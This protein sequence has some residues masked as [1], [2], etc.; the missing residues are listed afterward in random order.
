MSP[1][2]NLVW[3]AACPEISR[4][5][6]LSVS[7][8]QPNGCITNA[9]LLHGTIHMTVAACCHYAGLEHWAVLGKD[10][11]LEYCCRYCT[12]RDFSGLLF[13][14]VTLRASHSKILRPSGC[15][16]TS[17]TAYS[18]FLEAPKKA[19]A[20]LAPRVFKSSAKQSWLLQQLDSSVVMEVRVLHFP[21][22]TQQ[23]LK[24]HLWS[25]STY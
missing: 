23:R 18:L 2:G 7:L 24:S 14:A 10:A 25:G 9:Q 16:K 4:S 5:R 3:D 20:L 22:A 13:F 8:A 17:P 19:V 11:P 21:V 6:R 12:P 15:S 1:P